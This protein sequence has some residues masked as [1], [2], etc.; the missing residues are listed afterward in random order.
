MVI[1]FALLGLALLIGLPFLL[2]VEGHT[3]WGLFAL[4]F[5]PI[6]FV[7]LYAREPTAEGSFWYLF[8]AIAIASLGAVAWIAG[9]AIRDLRHRGFF[10]PRK[11]E[12]GGDM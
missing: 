4:I 5:P 12:E 8:Y 7:V 10:R 2:A 9:V 6:P 11:P 1:V 3:W